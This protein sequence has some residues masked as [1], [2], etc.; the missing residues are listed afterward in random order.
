M[1]DAADRPTPPSLLLRV[2]DPADAAA[3]RTFVD[4]YG[5]LVYGYCRGARLAH[6]DAEDVTQEVFGR[7]NEA[8]RT[9]EYRPQVARF[10]SWLAT[11]VRNEINR[12]FKKKG[13][14]VGVGADER[15]LADAVAG[16]EDTAWTAAFNAHV[17]RT[18]LD[19]C[20]PHF[21]ADTWKAFA[22]VWLEDRPAAE[23]GRTLGRPLEWVYVAKSRVLKRLWEEVVELADDSVVSAAPPHAL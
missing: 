7:V 18:A 14:A 12:L 10:R 8:I 22:L 2:R 23:A 4:I 6:E 9:F 17:L 21:E 5:P 19:R 1:G 13:R 3:W 20:R 15:V 11:V 16:T